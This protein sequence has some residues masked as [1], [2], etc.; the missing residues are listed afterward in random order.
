MGTVERNFANTTKLQ[1]SVHHN[2]KGSIKLIK[3]KQQS[4]WYY[5]MA[6]LL[7]GVW[8]LEAVLIFCGWSGRRNVMLRWGSSGFSFLPR[9]GLWTRPR[10]CLQDTAA[11]DNWHDLGSL[12][13]LEIVHL[14]F[15]PT[16]VFPAQTFPSLAQGCS[17]ICKAETS[18]PSSCRQ[19]PA[20]CT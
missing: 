16:G 18:H 3:H 6:Q 11:V 2:V 8:M 7:G 4:W 12:G 15:I 10:H 9:R 14:H 5:I 1:S 13:L 17:Q 20:S 19:D